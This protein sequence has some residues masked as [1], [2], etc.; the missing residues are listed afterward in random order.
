MLWWGG[1][2]QVQLNESD[3]QVQ[4]VAVLELYLD[5]VDRIVYK[6][7]LMSKFTQT[8]CHGGGV[9]SRYS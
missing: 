1:Q 4:M 5:R 8:G 3:L 6:C 9:R 7:T 2:E